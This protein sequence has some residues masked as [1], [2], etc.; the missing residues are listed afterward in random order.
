MK[1]G[2]SRKKHKV[3]VVE[4]AAGSVIV[5]SVLSSTIGLSSNDTSLVDVI[6][7][8]REGKSAYQVWLQDGNVGTVQDFLYARGNYSFPAEN[9]PAVSLSLF[10]GNNR[11]RI[12]EAYDGLNS[13]L[14]LQKK[15]NGVWQ[16]AQTLDY[17]SI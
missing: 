15:I 17:I 16:N 11:W 3:G 13:E 2:V 12:V 6:E 8:G 9:N 1:I 14:L 10:A 7:R 5:S 4:K